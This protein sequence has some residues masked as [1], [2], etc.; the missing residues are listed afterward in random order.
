MP[1]AA[2]NSRR[3]TLSCAALRGSK[4]TGCNGAGICNR[5]RIMTGMRFLFRVTLQRHDLAA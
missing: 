4:T 5:N 3:R 1:M 2:A